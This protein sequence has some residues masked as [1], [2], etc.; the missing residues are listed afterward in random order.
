MK[1][2]AN[3]II[4]IK[5]GTSSITGGGGSIDPDSIKRLAH[6]IFLL[7]RRNIRPVLV[8]SGAIKAGMEKL[9]IRKRPAKLATLQACAAAGQS[10]LM[11]IYN[12]IFQMY[13][14]PVAQI[15]VTRD[16][17]RSRDRFM[18]IRSTIHSLLSLGCLPIINE[19]D[20]VATEEIKFGENDTLS[21][22][23]AAAV[24]AELL[25]NL[26]DVDGLYTSDP[27]TDPEARLIPIVT[28]ITPEITALGGSSAGDM[29]SGGMRTKLKAALIA[30]SSGVN[31]VIAGAAEEDIITR[32]CSGGAC[33][34]LFAAAGKPLSPKKCWMAFAAKTDGS[35]TVNMNAEQRI[36][37]GTSL[38]PV[39]VTKV[40]GIFDSGDPVDIKNENGTVFAKGTV[41]YSSDELK[42]IMGRHTAEIKATLGYKHYDEAVHHNNMV[43]TG[44]YLLRS[45][46]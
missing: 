7:T 19:N 41:Y 27:K 1:I 34:T 5:I 22:I 38:L 21:A 45:K 39:G 24:G 46:K 35:L 44:D 29:G 30:V 43:L 16:D 40:E 14:I 2:S 37:N 20:T 11:E 25:I 3:S 32:I 13:K 17:F 6:E 8:S 36:I 10:A 12:F 23:A 26:S 33:G 4:L 9:G 18:N 31:M 15:L 42:R 28:K